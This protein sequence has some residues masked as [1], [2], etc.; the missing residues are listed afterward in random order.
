MSTSGGP[1]VRRGSALVTGAS[2]GVGRAVAI[3]LAPDC[4]E[5]LLVGRDAS[6]LA[7]VARAVEAAGARAECF[8][9][10]FGDRQATEALGAAV[11]ASRTT[12][13]V[14]VHS[15]GVFMSGSVESAPPGDFDLALDVNLRAPF[16]LSRAL[17]PQLA[18]GHGDV[19]FINSSAVGQRKAGLTAYG[20]S[21][22]GLVGLADSLRQEL[23]PSGV[24]VLS[25]FLGATATPMQ[26]QIYAQSGRSYQ[27]EA[28]LSA[29]DVARVVCDVLRL[30]R[31][32][33]VT[34]LH[35]RPAAPHRP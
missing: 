9:V 4:D 10:D 20:A 6:R 26:E 27:P 15:A 33:E 14:L 5:V 13:S 22:H 23:N 17:R 16:L 30:P 3:G 34:D 21:K 25:V 11:A 7:D 18:A 8:T 32:A 28:L 1:S 31:G 24:R 29:S 12:L 2:S 19:V 35:L